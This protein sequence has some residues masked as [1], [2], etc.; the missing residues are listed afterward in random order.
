MHLPL[1]K[2]GTTV[3]KLLSKKITK[4]ELSIEFK[5]AGENRNS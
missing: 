2:S 4:Y 3:L 5:T 1:A